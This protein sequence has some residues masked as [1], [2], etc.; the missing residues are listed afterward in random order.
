[1]TTDGADAGPPISADDF[2]V[3]PRDVQDTPAEVDAAFRA[4]R[5]VAFA[6]FVAFLLV[7]AAFPVLTLTVSW[8]TESRAVGDLSP[9]FLTVAVGLYVIFA[10]LGIAAAMRSGSVESRMLGGDHKRS[11]D[12]DLW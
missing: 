8:W 4:M 10:V 6:Y 2:R 7:I 5:K 12:E 11:D 1:M 3:V 9:G